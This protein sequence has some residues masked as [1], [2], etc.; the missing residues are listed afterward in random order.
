MALNEA[1]PKVERITLDLVDASRPTP[2]N[3]DYAGAPT[4]TLETVVSYPTRNGTALRHLPLVVFATGFGGTATNYA[5]VYDHWVRAGYVVAAPTFPLSRRDAPGGTSGIDLASQ[6]GDLRFV[7][8]QVLQETERTTSALHGVID[9]DVVAVAGK[10]MGGITV[11]LAGYDPAER[12]PRFRAVIAM[13]GLPM[14]TLRF[15]RYDTPLLLVHGDADEVVAVQ[16]SIDSYAKAQPPKYFVTLLGQTHTAAFDGGDQPAARV[17][18]TTT[19]DF[20]DAYVKGERAALLRL[21][22]DGD[23]PGVASMQADA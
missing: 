23:V 22:S 7:L 21:R 18:Y 19:T 20:L 13:T 15:D 16:G 17:V 9:P 4:R 1:S 2:A 10:S 6:P 14:D 8:D 12:E 5:P 11:L 3:K